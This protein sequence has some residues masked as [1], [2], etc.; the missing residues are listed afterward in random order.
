M[1]PLSGKKKKK[2]KKKQLQCCPVDR[3]IICDRGQIIGVDGDAQH[4]FE[5]KTNIYIYIYKS[6]PTPQSNLNDPFK[7]LIN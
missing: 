4:Q 2:K 6:R 7:R 3:L 1:L 5:T